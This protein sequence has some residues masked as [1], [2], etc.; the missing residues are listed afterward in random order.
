MII[1]PDA[2]RTASVFYRIGLYGVVG[3]AVVWVLI[4]ALVGI[5]EIASSSIPAAATSFI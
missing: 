2:G 3:G 1:P 5:S 4:L